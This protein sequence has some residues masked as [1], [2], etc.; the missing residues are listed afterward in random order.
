MDK[1][2]ENRMKVFLE[3]IFLKMMTNGTEWE[4]LT[5]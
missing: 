1:I 4:L 3:D 2:W 5:C